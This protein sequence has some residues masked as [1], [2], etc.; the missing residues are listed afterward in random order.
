MRQASIRR[1]ALCRLCTG[2]H[3]WCKDG[4][5]TTRKGGVAESDIKLSVKLK[6]IPVTER[7]RLHVFM[8]TLANAHLFFPFFFLLSYHASSSEPKRRCSAARDGLPL[9][10]SRPIVGELHLHLCLQHPRP[11]GLVIQPEL[12]RLDLLVKNRQRLRHWSS[13]QQQRQTRAQ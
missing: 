4:K 11:L 8:F 10:S 13:Q 12:L 9:Q 5:R 2:P 7:S 6:I 1:W 3:K